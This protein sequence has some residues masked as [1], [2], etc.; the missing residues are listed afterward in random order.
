MRLLSPNTSLG[1]ADGCGV[2]AAQLLEIYDTGK[3]R[4]KAVQQ[5]L[6]LLPRRCRI[7][8][9]YSIGALGKIAD[10]FSRVF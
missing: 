6:G 3:A 5:G 4:G 10:N 7:I 1:G 2:K 8:S 9:S